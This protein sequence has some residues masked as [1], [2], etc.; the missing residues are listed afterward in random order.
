MSA[1]TVARG[2]LRAG[3]LIERSL[4]HYFDRLEP[5]SIAVLRRDG[6]DF[7]N[8]IEPDAIVPANRE[9]VSPD[10]DDFVWGRGKTDA[11]FYVLKGNAEVRHWEVTH[12][13][14]PVQDAPVTLRLRQTPGQSWARLSVTSRGWAPLE[15]NPIDLDWEALTPLAMTRDEVLEKLRTPPP[16]IPELIVERSHIAL[17]QGANWAGDGAISYLRKLGRPATAQGWASLLRRSRR[18]PVSHEKFWLVGTDGSLPPG[19]DP[20]WAHMLDQALTDFSAELLSTTPRR[21][22]ANNDLALALTW[23]F[24]RCPEAAQDRLLVA[25]EAHLAQRA[26]PVLAPPH[27]IRVVTQGA[28]RAVTGADRLGRL[29]QVIARRPANNDTINA[30][31]MILTRREEAPAALSRALV[32]SYAAILGRELQEQ[33]ADHKFKVKFRNTL[34]AIAGLFRWR[35]REPHALLADREPV[36]AQL[37]ANLVTTEGMLSTPAYRNDRQVEQKRE[38]IRK[39][40]EFLDGGGDPDILRM[41][42]QDDEDEDE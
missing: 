26:D 36:A 4:P 39:I 37:R 9:Y 23:C 24:A 29:L 13:E 42:E 10:L 28:G 31:A 34:S 7:E 6:P 32:D 2:A 17:W 35:M 12:P 20:V 18:E 11:E 22:P 38:Q 21:H 27:A 25:L 8:L 1:A 33:V 5:I 19:L 30:L 3:R 14:A 15:R 41:I 16:T 40:V